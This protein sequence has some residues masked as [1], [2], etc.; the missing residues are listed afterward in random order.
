[1]ITG[2][3]NLRQLKHALM[4]TPKGNLCIMIPIKENELYEG[5]K[6]IYLDIV[7][8]EIKNKKGDNKDTHL[9]KQ[10]F[11]KERLEKMTDTEKNE[12][13]IIGNFRVMSGADAHSEPEPKGSDKVAKGVDD[14]PF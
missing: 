7:G 6:G 2:K 11:P 1:M 12:I 10:S 13:P 5:E 3:I 8:F 14:L 4:T 9:V